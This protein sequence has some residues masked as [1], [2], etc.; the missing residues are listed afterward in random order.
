VHFGAVEN[1]LVTDRR[2]REGSDDQRRWLE[3]LIHDAEGMRGEFHVVSTE[4]PAGD[5]LQKLGGVA[6]LLRFKMADS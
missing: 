5:Q 3:R 6:A 4:H 2:L 1:L